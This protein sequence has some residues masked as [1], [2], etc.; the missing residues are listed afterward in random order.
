MHVDAEDPVAIRRY[1]LGCPAWGLKS[2]SGSLFAPQT[3]ATAY[4]ASYA[5][6]FNGVEGNT[7]FYA[8]PKADT[9]RRWRDQTPETFSFCFKFPSV[10]SHELGLGH[11][12]EETSRFLHTIE[13]LVDRLGPL[14]LQLPP[15]F[16]PDHLP[17]L[18]R[19]LRA[20]PASFGY[21]VE[22]RH[23][24]Y[25]RGD[26]E[27]RATELFTELGV[28]WVTLDTR[29]LFSAD[30]KHPHVAA[31]QR[32]KPQLPVKPRGTGPSPIVRFVPHSDFTECRALLEPWIAQ[33]SSW[34]DEGKRPCF[35]MHAPDDAHAPEMARS[36]HRL[37]LAHRQD[38]GG[39]PEWPGEHEHQLS[40]F[41]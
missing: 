30:R 37:F 33:L 24:G 32:Q 26:A 8:L 10:I 25:F 11:A 7:T 41:S 4:L 16:G 28:D 3:P 39:I 38:I 15:S 14:M 23:L 19:Y 13:P 34:I 9:V 12:H 22:L 2:W 21:A 29:G 18:S 31:V 17:A 40:L 5:Q 36:F 6:I 35:F 27:R 20:L 1:V